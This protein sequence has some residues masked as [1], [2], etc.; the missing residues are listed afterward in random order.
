MN[1]KSL[2]PFPIW[3][4][5]WYA[6]VL[7]GTRLVDAVYDLTAEQLVELAREYKHSARIEL[8]CRPRHRRGMPRFKAAPTQHVATYWVDDKHLEVHNKQAI[9]GLLPS[10]E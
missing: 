3:A 6:H 2:N 9:K 7:V 4:D 8:F 10:A 1:L 5:M